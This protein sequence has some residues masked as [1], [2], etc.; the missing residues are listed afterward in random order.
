MKHCI[1]C[2]HF[3]A[4][5]RYCLKAQIEETVGSDFLEWLVTGSGDQPPVRRNTQYASM[6]RLSD[7]P[8]STEAKLFEPKE[9]K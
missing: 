5:T 7:M 6:M 3:H 4:E 8:C 9:A 1:D 2:K